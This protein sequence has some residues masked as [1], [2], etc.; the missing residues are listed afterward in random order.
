MIIDFD[1][2][3]AQLGVSVGSGR[4][5]TR[6]GR[7]VTITNWESVINNS[8]PIIG[9][10]EGEDIIRSWTEEGR[11]YHDDRTDFMDLFIEEL[12]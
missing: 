1:L 10:L 8:Y 3:L 2:E 11:Y 9:K 5:V 6:G 7:K 12:C 4:V